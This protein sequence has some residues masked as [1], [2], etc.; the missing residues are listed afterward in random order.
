MTDTDQQWSR[1]GQLAFD[2]IV[3]D[4][5]QERHRQERL[6]PDQVANPDYYLA[7]LMEEVGEA[8][9][10]IVQRRAL[11]QE[12]REELVQVA[13]VACRILE[14]IDHRPGFGYSDID[15]VKAKP[16]A[17]EEPDEVDRALAV[18]FD[19]DAGD[20]LTL[21]EWLGSLLATVWQKGEGF[22]GKRPWGNSGWESDPY[23]ALI[24]AGLIE[25][26]IN[27]EGDWFDEID[28]PAAEAL[29]AAAIDRLTGG[30]GGEG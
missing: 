18:R 6:F 11:D 30:P 14:L 13:A 10:A 21:A 17:V 15:D 4:I 27:E 19:S 25:G 26:K 20:D 23:P 12:V 2:G 29:I 1:D 24:R 8:A 28:E 16:A 7:I 5:R 22:S 3:I 9:K